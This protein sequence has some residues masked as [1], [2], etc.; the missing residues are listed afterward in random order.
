MSENKTEVKARIV[1]A[2][3]GSIK[4]VIFS[5]PESPPLLGA[6]ASGAKNA[7]AEDVTVAESGASIKEF[8]VEEPA[9]A[10]SAWHSAHVRLPTHSFIRPA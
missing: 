4:V 3:D 8:P 7:P 1:S 5:A 9:P 2:E 6:K 10:A